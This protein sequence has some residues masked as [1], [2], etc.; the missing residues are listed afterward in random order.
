MTDLGIFNDTALGGW[1][2]SCV[3]HTQ[4]YYGNYYANEKWEVPASSGRTL[5]RALQDWLA[6]NST[7]NMHVDDCAW[8]CNKPCSTAGDGERGIGGL[9][10]DLLPL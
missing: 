4:A 3:A 5:A 6:A 1:I 7:A 10:D 8:P 2:D 9:M